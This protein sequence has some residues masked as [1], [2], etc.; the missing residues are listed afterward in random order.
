MRKQNRNET[1]IFPGKLSTGT[2][3][4]NAEHFPGND[5]EIRESEK[6][7]TEGGT[8]FLCMIKQCVI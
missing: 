2:R 5:E 8:S 7:N 6:E 4:A 1:R 3:K